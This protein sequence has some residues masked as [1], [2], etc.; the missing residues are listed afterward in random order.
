MPPQDAN[1]TPSFGGF[2]FRDGNQEIYVMNADGSGQTNLTDNSADDTY[3]TWSPDGV[4]IAF[5]SDRDGDEEIYSMKAS[6]G[7]DQTNLTNDPGDD[8]SPD[9]SLDGDKIVFDSSR[10]PE[11]N[12]QE[13]YEMRPDGSNQCRIT[14][15]SVDDGAPVWSPGIPQ[16]SIC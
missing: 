10:D 11:T 5:Q 12:K 8:F 15:N 6:D 1:P 13:I 7:S 14:D 9:W 16:A 3:P 2:G 4:R